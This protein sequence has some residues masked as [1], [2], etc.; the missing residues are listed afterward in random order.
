MVPY[1]LTMMNSE[2]YILNLS[3]IRNN[4]NDYPRKENNCG[5]E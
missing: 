1:N 3:P 4:S 5:D 2:D